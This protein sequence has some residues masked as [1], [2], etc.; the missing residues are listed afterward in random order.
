MGR[1]HRVGQT[2]DVELFNLIAMDTREGE[3]LSV[4]LDN[5]VIAANQLG[6]KL[7][8]SLSL[9]AELVGLNM[10]QLLSQTFADV[11]SDALLAAKAITATMFQAEATKAA[12]IENRYKSQLDVQAATERLQAEALERVN[13]RIVEA[14]LARVAAA[15]LI[16]LDRSA[17]GE[18]IFVISPGTRPLP[19]DF[20]AQ[21]ALVASS[22]TAITRA[23]ETGGRT[24]DVVRI[25]PAESAFRALVDG[26]RVDCQAALI[27]GSQLL[28]ESS[29]TA[30]DLYCFETELTEGTSPDP[31][32]HLALIR[33]DDAGARP[34]RWELLANLS[35]GDR[36]PGSP[37][38]AR[39]ADA[40][41]AATAEAVKERVTRSLTREKWLLAAQNELRKLP[42][43]ISAAIK[44]RDERRETRSRLEAAVN[45][46]LRQLGGLARVSVGETRQVGWSRV[47]PGGPPD[48]PTAKDSERISMKAVTTLLRGDGWRVADVHT[49]G[50]GYDLLAT[51]SHEQ[52]C[53]EVKGVWESASSQGVP[54]TAN[55]ILIAGQLADDYWLYVVDQCRDGGA[56]F[57]VYRDPITLFAD[58]LREVA[59]A[60]VPGSALSAAREA[61]RA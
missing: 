1:I 49:E 22:G 24:T 59:G 48:E 52:R 2:R 29:S 9:V 12:G 3:A 7:F 26:I 36:S 5:M 53:V 6:G 43:S 25:G 4:L 30:Y 14:F 58:Q 10:E 56:L 54:L 60:K 11:P 28:D 32:P 18:G 21:R 47:E 15:G 37:H 45:E 55:E 57:G 19:K 33:V 61:V 42:T 41:E 46:R 39:Q 16:R 8:D 35:A 13:P 17:L 51:R 23:E 44:D 40:E 27:Q 20:A 31:S 38:P 34:V 50:R